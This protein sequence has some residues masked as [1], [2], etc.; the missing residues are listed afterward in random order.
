MKVAATVKIPEKLKNSKK[1][2]LSEIRK[3]AKERELSDIELLALLAWLTGAIAAYQSDT[4]F[5]EETVRE[6]IVSNI[7]L[8]NLAAATKIHR[9]KHAN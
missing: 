5:S 2:L 9:E 3:A 6:I 7:G 8:G 1:A 4:D